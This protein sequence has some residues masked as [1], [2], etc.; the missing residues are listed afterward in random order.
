MYNAGRERDFISIELVNGH[1]HYIFDLGDGPVKIK[2]NLK[3][4]LNDG[5]W[6]SV[7]IG[8]PA[9]KRHT[10]AVDDHLISVTSAGSNEN[11]DLDRI[12]YIGKPKR[13]KASKLKP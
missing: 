9:P 10:L 8:R 4:R 3:T 6:H 2:D 11:L 13:K 7:A 1:I 12:L 5:K